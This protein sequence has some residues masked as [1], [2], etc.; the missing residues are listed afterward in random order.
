MDFNDIIGHEQ[1]ILKLQNAIKNDSI[2]HSYIFEGPKSMGKK[3]LAMVFAKTLLCEEKGIEPCNKCHS[4]LKF[5]SGNH[6]DFD[7]INPE[8]NSIKREQIEKLLHSIRMLPYEGMRRVYVIEDAYKMTA[9]A[10]NSF[11]KTLEEP[12]EYAVIILI[13]DKSRSLLPTI[14]SRCQGIK[15]SYVENEKIEKLLVDKYGCSKEEASFIASFSNG[16]VGKAVKLIQSE[17]FRKLRDDIIFAIDDIIYSDKFR[18]FSLSQTFV[19]NKDNIEDILDLLTIWFRDIMIIKVAG[20]TRFIMNKD[21]IELIYKHS[22]TLSIEKVS[23]IIENIEKTKEDI[24]SNVN[25][26][27]AIEVMLLKVQQEV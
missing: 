7:I 16:I 22:N 1:N 19:E 15:F 24:T 18:I 20:D 23:D 3:K 6:P 5:D 17:E 11:L 12:P 4:C 8:G 25:F 9:E 21:K 2:A 14:V 26:Q 13:T 10:Q 27:L